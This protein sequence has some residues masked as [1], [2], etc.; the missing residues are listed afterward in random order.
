MKSVSFKNLVLFI[1]VMLCEPNLP[2]SSVKQLL[3]VRLISSPS[4]RYT[5]TKQA[6]ATKRHSS[7]NAVRMMGGGK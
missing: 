7:E 4:M 6:K 2:S 3:Q 1:K 5:I